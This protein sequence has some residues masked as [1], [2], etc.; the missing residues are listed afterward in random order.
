[1]VLENNNSLGIDLQIIDFGDFSWL[2]R[3]VFLAKFVLTATST[4]MVILHTLDFLVTSTRLF[5]YS[6]LA[7]WCWY[8]CP[9]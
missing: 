7:Y 3:G 6:S 5:G 9:C 8:S 1:M 2:P 4:V